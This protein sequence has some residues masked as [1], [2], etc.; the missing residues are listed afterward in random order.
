[1]QRRDRPGG[2]CNQHQHQR[3]KHHDWRSELEL[4]GRWTLRSHLISSFYR[5][6]VVICVI[7]DDKVVIYKTCVVRVWE[8]HP[9]GTRPLPRIP[10]WLLSAT[11]VADSSQ[12]EGIS[13]GLQPSK[14]LAT[15]AKEN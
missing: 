6:V 4:V 5:V 10:F 8:R 12:R 11:N 7:H 14:P 2:D 9:G 13:E 3:A 1:Q 15:G